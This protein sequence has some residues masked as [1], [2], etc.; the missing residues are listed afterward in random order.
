MRNPWQGDGASRRRRRG[1]DRPGA[2]PGASPYDFSVDIDDQVDPVDLLA[3]RA[4]DELLDALAAGRT[5]GGGPSIAGLDHRFDSG[6]NDDQQVLAMLQAWRTDVESEPF[7]EMISIEEASEAIVA[8]QRAAR[9]RRRLVPV[10]AAA[11]VAVMALSGVA[12]GASTAQPGDPLWGV[13]SLLNP[14][15]A[16]SVE[17]ADRVNVA[18]A[19]AQQALAEGRPADARAALAGVA[20][21][22]EHVREQQRRE[23]LTRRSENLLDVADNTKDGERVDTRE[24]GSPKD[25]EKA[26]EHEKRRHSSGRSSSSSS[27]SSGSGSS[28]GSSGSSGSEKPGSGGPIYD[29]RS[30]PDYPKSE[31]GSSGGPGFPLPGNPGF[32]GPNPTNVPGFPGS[33]PGTYPGFPGFPGTTPGIPGFPGD[34]RRESQ[35]PSEQPR[36]SPDSTKPSDPARP[37]P[38]STRPSD[39]TRPGPESRPTPGPKPSQE[40]KPPESKP[41]TDTT[42]PETTKPATETTKQPPDN[43]KQRNKPSEGDGNEGGGG[44]GSGG[45]GSGGASGGGEQHEKP[46]GQSR[47]GHAENFMAPA[48]PYPTANAPAGNAPPPQN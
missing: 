12:I 47:G 17:A 42:R 28:G 26:R 18:L 25:S 35:K 3:I 16:K 10:A 24:D 19:T 30:A 33:N 46:K 34:P 11:A 29:P 32:P 6:Y 43:T 2:P 5:I 22:L 4:D 27:S 20:P 38:D 36:P 8:G 14:N 7:P 31:T 13:S 1:S 41:A 48:R 44:S 37:A 39:S 15:R 21:D 9:P 45:S 40:P 23:E